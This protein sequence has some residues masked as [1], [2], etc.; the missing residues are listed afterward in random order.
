MWLIIK[1]EGSY[2]RAIFIFQIIFLFVFVLV[3]FCFFSENAFTMI[4]TGF[5][6]EPVE[7][8]SYSSGK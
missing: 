3:L 1:E 2:F 6:Q 7:L 4:G 5:C 8:S